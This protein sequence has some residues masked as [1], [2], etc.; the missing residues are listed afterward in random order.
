M[1]PSV[2][3][4][5]HQ[6]ALTRASSKRSS[7]HRTEALTHYSAIYRVRGVSQ[8]G[9]EFPVEISVSSYTVRGTARFVGII[10]DLSVAGRTDAYGTG[11]G[12]V[13]VE[14]LRL[15]RLRRQAAAIGAIMRET[16]GLASGCRVTAQGGAAAVEDIERVSPSPDVA[17]IGWRVIAGKCA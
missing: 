6:S 3:R 1:M 4:V 14:V 15:A 11:E 7:S 2:Y 16:H 8:S 13:D 9:N 12:A 10:K 17:A 5:R